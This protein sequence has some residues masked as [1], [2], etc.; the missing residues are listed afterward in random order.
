[1]KNIKNKKKEIIII[2]VLLTVLGTILFVYLNKNKETIELKPI[3]KK[4]VK[5]LKILD[6]K[7]TT[8]PYGV[9]INNLGAARG[10]QSGL[11][12]AYIIYEII[13]E[14]GIT[15]YFALFIDQEVERIGSIRSARHYFLDY[16]LENDAL[17]VHH[18]QSPQAARDFGNLGI[19]RIVVD[20]SKTGFRDYNITGVN[21]EHKLFTSTKHLEN[22]LKGKREERNKDLLLEYSIDSLKLKE[23]EESSKVK[24]FKVPYSSSI[25]NSYIYDEDTKLYNRS[26][27]GNPQK[28]YV[29]GEQLAVKNIIVYNVQNYALDNKGRQNIN[30]IGEGK[31]YFIS[32]GYMIPIKWKKESRSSQ[33]KYTYNGEELK[34]NDGNTFIQ[35]MPSNRSIQII[36]HKEEGESE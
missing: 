20:N 9:M 12:D 32:E 3:I 13:V 34:V 21:S 22:G 6:P 33:T 8:R 23:Y 28:D 24:E 19:A 26:V 30:N 14:G 25:V 36:E 1:M 29:T 2:L 4:K 27:N 15:R 31:G 16:A 35:I 5:K 11:N 10:L 17:Y 18:G 7:T